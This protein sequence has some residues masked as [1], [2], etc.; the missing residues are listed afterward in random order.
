MGKDTNTSID[1]RILNIENLMRY[2]EWKVF[3]EVVMTLQATEQMKLFSKKF[4][5]LSAEEKDKE[6]RAIIR[7]LGVLDKLLHLPE[8]LL[9]R[10]PEYWTQVTNYLN[11]ED[12]N[13]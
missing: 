12:N 9:K 11:E 10:K 4:L 5:N 13:G 2:S 7:S 1:S 3:E 8:W 6:H